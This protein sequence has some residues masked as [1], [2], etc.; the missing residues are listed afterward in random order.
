M[1]QRAEQ[2]AKE[3]NFKIDFYVPFHKGFLKQ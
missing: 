1:Q 3:L 2:V